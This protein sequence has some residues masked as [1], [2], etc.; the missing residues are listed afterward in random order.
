M[1]LICR[2]CYNEIV[3]SGDYPELDLMIHYIKLHNNL[4]LRGMKCMQRQ[5]SGSSFRNECKYYRTGSM[6]SVHSCIDFT[7]INNS[8]SVC[9][10]NID[11]NNVFNDIKDSIVENL[12]YYI[13]NDLRIEII[14]EI[15][16]EDIKEIETKFINDLKTGGNIKK[17]NKETKVN[18]NCCSC[19]N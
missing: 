4:F 9:N 7:D 5:Y 6:T 13:R 1:T 16:K 15:Q 12:K 11:I 19:K 14:N 18:R 10:D 2:E 17:E 8:D 3:D